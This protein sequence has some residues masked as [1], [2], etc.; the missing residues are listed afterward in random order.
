MGLIN[1]FKICV[2]RKIRRIQSL[3]QRSL[4]RCLACFTSQPVKMYVVRYLDE[5]LV[6]TSGSK[7]FS[8]KMLTM[9]L[10]HWVLKYLEGGLELKV[11]RMKTLTTLCLQMWTECCL[12]CC[13]FLCNWLRF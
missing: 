7:M 3:N 8:L 12:F 2:F 4:F 5:I 11:D 13:S 1:K 9:D 10:K 6:I